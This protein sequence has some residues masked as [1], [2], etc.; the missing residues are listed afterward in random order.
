MSMSTHTKIKKF[1]TDLKKTVLY[2]IDIGRYSEFLV[3]DRI[4]SE[5]VV[6]SQP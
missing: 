2:R 5:K 1:Y 3:S 4:D 6:S